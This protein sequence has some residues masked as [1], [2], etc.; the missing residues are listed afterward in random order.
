MNEIRYYT[1][2][3]KYF[4]ATRCLA[5]VYSPDK[6]YGVRCWTLGHEE[7]AETFWYSNIRD[8]Q[9]DMEW[10]DE[11]NKNHGYQL[12]SKMNIE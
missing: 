3:D 12:V 10:W 11:R 6:Y 4:S 2:N 8:A 1:L 7:I 9:E 5:C